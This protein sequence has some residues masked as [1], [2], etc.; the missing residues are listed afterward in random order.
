MKCRRCLADRLLDRGDRLFVRY[1]QIFPQRVDRAARF[2]QRE[3]HLHARNEGLYVEYRFQQRL[4]RYGGR[5]HLCT[6]D[7]RLQYL[8]KRIHKQRSCSELYGEN[9]KVISTHADKIPFNKQMKESAVFNAALRAC[10]VKRLTEL[11]AVSYYYPSW[12]TEPFLTLF[13]TQICGRPSSLS[14]CICAV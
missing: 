4:R 2:R 8:L 9:S 3:K 5:N 7:S 6:G 14:S 11:F 10:S 1:R 12:R 13:F